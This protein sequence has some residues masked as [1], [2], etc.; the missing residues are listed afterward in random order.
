V[1][2]ALIGASDIRLE[3]MMGD[4]GI[5]QDE[6]TEIIESGEQQCQEV[7]TIILG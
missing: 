4:L 2:T 6:L 7:K 3:A 5:D 1:D